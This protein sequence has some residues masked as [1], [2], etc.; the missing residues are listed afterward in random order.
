[1]D[2]PP[3]NLLSKTSATSTRTMLPRLLA[4][5]L[6][7][8]GGRYVLYVC[9][10]TLTGLMEAISLA[11]VVP[12]LAALGVGSSGAQA[13]GRLGGVAA[14]VLQWIGAAPTTFAIG[15]VVVAALVLST[16]LFMVQAYIGARLQTTY[17]YRW[18]QRLARAIFGAPWSYFLNRRQG[19]LVN[20]LVNETQRVGGAFY[21]VG[22]LLT[23]VIHSVLFLIIAAAL[24]GATTALVMTGAAV[25][26]FVTRPLIRRS[27]SFGAGIAYEDALLQSLA[28]ELV[29]GAKLVKATATERQAIELLTG[30]ADRL[31]KHVLGYAFDVQIIKGVFEFGAASMGAI[32]LVV[33]QSMLHVDPAVTLVVLAIFV[34]LMPKL[35]SVQH[36]LQSLS[37]ILPAVEVIQAFEQEAKSQAEAASNNPLPERLREGP[38]AVRLNQ[39]DVR[40]G[41]VEALSAVTLEI[42]PGFCV[43]LV[44]GSSAGKSTLV[45]AVLGLVPI[46]S[47]S[48][49][50]HGESLDQLPLASLRRRVGYMGQ[51]TVLYNASIRD[52]VLWGNPDAGAAALDEATRV[53]GADGF[54]QKMSQGYDA[55]VGDRGALL[56]GGERQRLGLARAVLGKP[57]LLILDEATSALDAET[58]RAV[59]DAVAALKGT[60]TIVMIAHRLSSVRIAD[61]ICVMEQG[62]IVEQGSWSELIAR[63]GR[64]HQLWRLQHA[65]ERRHVEA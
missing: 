19:D 29:S 23:G 28:S 33:S 30:S 44:G 25:L 5:I 27:Y 21:Q 18:Q 45:D 59:I 42:R 15:L 10:V 4:D 13:G 38:L 63:G 41:A 65:E 58:E 16:S 17:V 34:R 57:G 12:L 51:E 7:V 46:T 32:I 6:S 43:A 53:A 47:G 9:L 22:L 56:A 37:F 49:S 11:S 1:M 48:I 52:N 54:I 62:R 3:L 26:F 39:V 24:S 8:V 50:I 64:F 20:A 61:T 14:S 55:A 2:T 36:G 40:Y 35:T 60:T 31:R